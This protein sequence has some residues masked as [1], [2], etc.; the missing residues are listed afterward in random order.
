MKKA[1]IKVA[2]LALL[3][4]LAVSCQK[5]VLTE[6]TSSTI[7]TMDTK[8]NQFHIDAS[9]TQLEFR[10]LLPDTKIDREIL[11]KCE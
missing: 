3:G 5:E 7:P 10:E 2:I 4:P 9:G 1:I 6:P 11:I 8:V